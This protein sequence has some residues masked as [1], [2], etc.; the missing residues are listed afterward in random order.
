M[1]LVKFCVEAFKQKKNVLYYSFELKERII[2]TRID[3][4]LFN[5]PLS[6]VPEYANVIKRGI[7][8]YEKEGAKIFIKEY[9]SGSAT[10]NTIRNHVKTLE[11]DHKFKPDVIFVDYADI[12][13]ATTSFSENRHNLTSI[14]VGLRGLAGELDV[15]I[16]TASQATRDAI[17]SDKFD[18]KSISESLGKAQTADVVIGLARNDDQKRVKAASLLLLKNRF[19]EDGIK[20]PLHFDTAYINISATN[21]SSNNKVKKMMQDTEENILNGNVGFGGLQ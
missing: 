11:R 16:W 18:L 3:S 1:M 8:D 15:P 10:I 6:H 2:G 4:C 9:P 14:Y 21:Q 7:E 20:M 17:N 13:K 5:L 19:G 12:M